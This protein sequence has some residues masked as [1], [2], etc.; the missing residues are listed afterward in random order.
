MFDEESIENK[1]NISI[2]AIL[3]SK[4]N[5]TLEEIREQVTEEWKDYVPPGE[6]S[7]E[8]LTEINDEDAS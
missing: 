8:Y 4:N 2:K 6:D 3:A 5:A 1:L 7:V